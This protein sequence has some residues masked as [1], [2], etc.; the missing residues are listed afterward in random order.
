MA[1]LSFSG[2]VTIRARVLTISCF[3]F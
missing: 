1:S 2:E 3:V